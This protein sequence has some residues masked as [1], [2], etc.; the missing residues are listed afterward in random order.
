MDKV[1]AIEVL[2]KELAFFRPKSYFELK[3]MVGADPITKETTSDTDTKYQIE[4]MVHWDDK[5]N[6]NIRVHGC[7]DDGG[8]R[9]FFPLSSDF[10]ISTEGE[11]IDE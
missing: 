10:I 2:E 9:A 8:W 4:I 3:N 6:G 5:P 11:F 1:E 7:I